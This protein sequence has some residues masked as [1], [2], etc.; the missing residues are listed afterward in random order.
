[1]EFANPQYLWLISI[2]PI[3]FGIKYLY[4]IK[5]TK[6]AIFLSVFED[7][8]KSTRLSWYKILPIIKNI[9]LTLAF[10]FI[11]IALARPQKINEETKITKNG[12]DILITI[13]VSE[14]MLAQDLK[15]NRIEA[16]KA[17][18]S[19]FIK[20]LTADRVGLLVFAGKPFTGSPMTFDYD[21]VD[22][23]VQEISTEMVNQRVRGLSGTAIGDAILSGV[24]RLANNPERSKV[25][26]LLT[27][28]EANVG[29]VDPIFAAEHAR[30][31]G[32]KIYT[33]GI[34]NREGVP[35]PIGIDQNGK[36]IYARNLDG[37][38]QKTN[39][40]EKTLQQIAQISGGTYFYAGDNQ[41]LEKVFT[42]IQNLEKKEYETQSAVTYEE[43]YWPYL[44]IGYLLLITYSLLYF[45]ITIKK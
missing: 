40:D 28:G 10:G 25:L 29:A 24:N 17:Y 5:T 3:L 42:Q 13:D 39:L 33:I 43:K 19:E 45:Y 36:N 44:C 15:P 2:I 21:V 34:G 1:M 41:S 32:V 37:T 6:P 11:I 9:L 31:Q 22:F 26:I 12:I 16:A 38:L 23:Y 4:Q 7:A 27:D 14:S 20:K 35:I 30:A 18:I 8:K